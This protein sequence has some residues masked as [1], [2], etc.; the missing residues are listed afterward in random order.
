M[1]FSSSPLFVVLN[2]YA[3]RKHGLEQ[4]TKI[5]KPILDQAGLPYQLIETSEKGH[6]Q[7]FIK[8]YFT[9][10]TQLST[11]QP[12]MVVGGDGTVHELVNGIIE[13]LAACPSLSANIQPRVEFCI[14]PVGTGNAIA[15]SLG[16]SSVQDAVDRLIA[17]NSTP[18]KV[19]EVSR[20]FYEN[21]TGVD[22]ESW[23][24]LLYTAVVSSFGLHC[25][26]VKDAE[27]LRFLGKG[28]FKISALK[29]IIFLKQYEGSITIHGPFQQY[30]RDRNEMVPESAI[31]QRLPGP[32]TYLVLSKQKS[33]SPG[34][35]P[36]PLAKTSD[37]WVDVL[38]VQ[39]AS[40]N[41]MIQVLRGAKK[42]G[43][44]MR[45][46]K[47]EYYKAR[48]IE[49]DLPTSGRLCIDGEFLE[50]EAGS[51]GR[52]RFEIAHESAQIFSVY[53]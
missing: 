12:I 42:G 2:P 49:L 6:A 14:V 20:R 43:E 19:I 10:L 22:V 37:D 47:V 45:H 21:S 26:T 15:T 3:G 29:N 31:T 44:H 46:E 25:V 9:G 11:P 52:L 30:T 5:I 48:A 16:I 1:S 24:P 40:R 34:F 41:E 27:R 23:K 39:N 4:F 8:D 38:V 7:S 17:G 35:T 51:K 32:F 36:T 13:G 28:R 53:I 33:L 50:M 18:M